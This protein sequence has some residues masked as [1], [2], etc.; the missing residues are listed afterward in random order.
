MSNFAPAGALTEVAG[1]VVHARLA[2]PL[3]LRELVHVGGDRLLGEVVSLDR[4]AAIIQVYEE[5]EGLAPGPKR[6]SV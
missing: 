6:T 5:T 2:M 4:D 3:A 1:S